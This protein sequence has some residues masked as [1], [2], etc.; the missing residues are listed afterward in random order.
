[1]NERERKLRTEKNPKPKEIR[2]SKLPLYE[3]PEPGD[4]FFWIKAPHLMYHANM[5][6]P[7]TCLKIDST[8]PNGVDFRALSRDKFSW[9]VFRFWDKDVALH[10]AN[11]AYSWVEQVKYADYGIMRGRGWTFRGIGAFFGPCKWGTGAQARLLKYRDR[12][13]TPKNV[14]CSEMCVLA[15]QL[16]MRENDDS[17]IMLDAK[18]TLPEDLYNYFLSNPKYWPGVYYRP[19]TN[20]H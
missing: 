3:E 15:Y 16:C 5:I 1:M 2:L 10:A 7:E 9:L 17:F 12:H 18:H 14:I 6:A 19:G 11:L 20:G 8:D 13:M 4:V